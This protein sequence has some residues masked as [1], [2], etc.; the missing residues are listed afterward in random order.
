MPKN[1]ESFSDEPT[2]LDKKCAELIGLFDASRPSLDDFRGRRNYDEAQ[3][4]RDQAALAAKEANYD[5]HGGEISALDQDKVLEAMLQYMGAHDQIFVQ[6]SYAE[7]STD[8][9]D[10]FNGADVIF[11]L[12]QKLGARDVV[13]NVDA[14]TAITPAAIA[15]KFNK[16][17]NNAKPD[18]PG[19]N[20]LMYFA[21]GKTRT[22][23]SPSP[24]Y[25]IGAMP[26]CVSNAA[27]K[28]DLDD[29]EITNEVDESLRRKI[30]I[31]LYIQSKTGALA[32]KNIEDRTDF[33]EKAQ[34]AHKS[35]VKASALALCQSFNIDPKKKDAASK[36]TKAIN[37]FYDAE[38]HHDDTFKYIWRE[39]ITRYNRETAIA[40]ARAANKTATNLGPNPTPAMA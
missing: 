3:I 38:C 39:S 1:Y 29:A 12:P 36:L 22:R 23:I 9:D 37:D 31:E 34:K 21:H 17:E 14:C 35:V 10:S 33:T 5:Y 18:S 19:C 6:E 24:H 13:F 11:G 26:A 27:D 20:R 4:D 30:L 25:I 32:C 28:F 2:E 40:K 7:P 15:K 16:T 8:Y